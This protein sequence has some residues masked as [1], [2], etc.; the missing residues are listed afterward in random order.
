MSQIK[1]EAFLP[2]K[3][4]FSGDSLMRLLRDIEHE[5]GDRVTIEIKVADAA[6][7]EENNLSALPALVVEDLVRFIGVCPDKETMA[8]AL[9]DAGLD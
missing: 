2:A 1:I 7:C 6:T 5:Y 3:P 8:N 9:K 4:S